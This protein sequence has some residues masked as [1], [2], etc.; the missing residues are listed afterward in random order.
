MTRLNDGQTIASE[1]EVFEEIIG[2]FQYLYISTS[3]LTLTSIHWLI[4]HGIYNWDDGHGRGLAKESIYIYNF[5][6][7]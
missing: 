3:G 7:K 1:Y 6:T 2:M 4:C 5:T